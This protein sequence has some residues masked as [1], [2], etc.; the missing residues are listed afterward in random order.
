MWATPHKSSACTRAH[1]GDCFFVCV[2]GAAIHHNPNRIKQLFHST[3]DGVCE[4]SFPNGA[5]TTVHLTDAQIA[6]GSTAG[7]Q[8]LWLNVLEEGF[9]QVRIKQK[10][11]ENGDIPIDSISRGGSANA[12]ISLLTG[13]K[14]V[15]LDVLKHAADEK[16]NKHLRDVLIAGTKNRYL[17]SAGTPGHDHKLPPGIVSGHAYGVLGFDDAK[18]LVHLWNP[19][20]NHFQPKKEPASL[21]NGYPVKD[22]YF[23]VPFADFVKIYAYLDHETPELL[24][25]VPKKK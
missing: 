22:G 19:W 5:R 23:D 11:R 6:L 20:G 17:M 12:S 4:L 18:D 21:E 13:H 25:P 15:Q 10:D 8:G 9:G 24:K 7:P 3:K 16:A 14:A 2:V 1:L